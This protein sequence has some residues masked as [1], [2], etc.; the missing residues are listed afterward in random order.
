MALHND[1]FKQQIWEWFCNDIDSC[2][3]V[4]QDL[5]TKRERSVFKGGLNF[6]AALTTFSIIELMAGYH[7]GREPTYT[8]IAEFVSRYVG[9]YCPK[10]ADKNVAKRWYDVFRHGL[11]HQWSPKRGGVA[12]RFDVPD[13]LAFWSPGGTEKFPYLNVPSLFRCLKEALRDYEAD[14]DSDA[15][16]QEKFKRRYERL[17]SDDGEA[18]EALRRLCGE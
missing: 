6:P 18:M 8:D 11:S 9:K 5:Q 7:A 4:S 2:F 1:V 12:M 17:F 16:L 13:V 10:L 15:E 14:L 3:K